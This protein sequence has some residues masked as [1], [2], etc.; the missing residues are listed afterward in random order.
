M[1]GSWATFKRAARSAAAP[2]LLSALCALA[3]CACSHKEPSGG[4]INV[5]YCFGEVGLS[6]GQFSYP[7]CLDH[8]KTS[9]WVI[10]KQARVQR[11]D[12][13]TGECQG[14]WQ[15]PEWVNGKPTGVTVWEPEGSDGPL[16]F[17]PDTH[18]NRVMVFDGGSRQHPN[19]GQGVLLTRFGSYG[20]GPGQFIFTTDVAILPTPDGKAIARLYVSEYEEVDRISV[21]EPDHPLTKQDLL[22]M[23]GANL[24]PLPG[25]PLPSS[26]PESPQAQ[27]PNP[28]SKVV[29]NGND[30]ESQKTDRAKPA[31]QDCPFHFKY[32]IGHYGSGA[33]PSDI[34][35]NRP[36]SL[37][38]DLKRQELIVTDACNHRIGRFT[39]DGK[40][41]TWISGPD[42]VGSQPGQ[43]SYPYG[44]AL[45]DDGSALVSEFGGNRVQHIDLETGASLGIYGTAGRGQGQVAS[46]WGVTIMGNTAYVLDSGNNRVI[47]FD[48]PQG[49]KPSS[50]PSSA[51][52]VPRSQGGPG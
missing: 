21:Y 43:F 46:P 3:L 32:S 16:L 47:G 34:Q 11:L 30:A 28:G 52:R 33:S 4:P 44:L 19:E 25:V 26:R 22:A 5:K 50:I 29:P 20:K 13:K 42:K 35:F 6:P 2:V 18:Y 17:I 8:D 49:R 1:A 31:I 12:P 15:M 24:V 40:L 48:A 39:F 7:R 37:A 23:A 36:Q 45:L 14:G 41:I 9:L 27:N 38:L 10:D 51:F